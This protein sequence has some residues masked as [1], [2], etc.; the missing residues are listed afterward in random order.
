MPMNG[1][2]MHLCGK[3]RACDLYTVQWRRGKQ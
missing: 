1:K 2:L 3:L